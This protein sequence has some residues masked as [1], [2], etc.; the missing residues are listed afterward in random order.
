[1]NFSI[2]LLIFCLIV[3]STNEKAIWKI[4]ISIIELP[5]SPF[6]QSLFCLF[7]LETFL[8]GASMFISAISYWRIDPFII[9][10]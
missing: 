10:K 9:I 8:L 1:M 2:D 4:T 7:I 6:S 3:V 5:I